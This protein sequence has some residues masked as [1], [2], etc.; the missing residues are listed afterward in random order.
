MVK[1]KDIKRFPKLRF[2]GFKGE[3]EQLSL[4]QI[5]K[6][7]NGKAHE[8]EIVEK[9]RFIVVNS[10]FISTDGKV[11][12]Y[13]N[14]L[15]C[16]LKKSE[17][18]MVMSDIPRGKALAKCYYI[19][20]E[21]RYTLNQRIC[22]LYSINHS[23]KFLFYRLNRHSYFLKFDS[24]V[25]QTNLRKDEIKHCPLNVPESTIEQEKIASFIS[26]IDNKIQQLM[27][28]KELLEQYKK[29]VMQKI[30]SQEIRFT[31]DNGKDY[32]DWE[33]KKLGDVAKFRRGSFPQPYG[34]AK[35]YDDKNGCPFVQVFDVDD[36]LK[37]KNE[38]KKKISEEAKRNSVFVKKGSVVLTIQGSIGRIAI[39][40]YDAYVDRT[41][42][43]F[44]S[45][46]LSVDIVF[47]TYSVFLLFKKEKLKAPGGT[48]KTITKEK[49]TDFILSVPSI[50]EQQKIGSFLTSIDKKIESVQ[51]QITQTQIFKKGLLQQ[52]FV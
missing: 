25:G 39:T 50:Y 11:I 42:L 49:L 22:G 24:G 28:R 13:A 10:K 5:A 12:K 51:S 36:N 21:E 17:V 16:P 31:D 19:E 43:I 33:E 15:I 41:L 26:A 8:Q 4:G 52:L 44:T 7:R 18:V 1:T 45:Y 32:P 46:L 38:T 48:I 35:W 40:Q 23:N 30:F 47:F 3:W 27:A 20:Q 37:L 29:G 6:F 2:P 34:L 14:R 9:G